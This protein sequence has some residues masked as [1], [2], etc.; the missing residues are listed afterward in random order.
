MLV[1]GVGQMIMLVIHPVAEPAE[2]VE[3]V[4]EIINHQV[5]DL[6]NQI[7][8]EVPVV[9]PEMLVEQLDK[10]EDQE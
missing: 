9:V 1:A 5:Q 7:Q 6:D 3:G 10:P 8:E 2:L 4:K